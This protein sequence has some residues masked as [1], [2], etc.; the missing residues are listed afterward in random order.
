MKEERAEGIVLKTFDYKENER[1]VTVFTSHEGV[2]ALIAKHIKNQNK[3]ALTTPFCQAEFLFTKGKSDLCKLQDGTILND[4]HFL[5][6][7]LPHL[8][9]AAEMVKIVLKS[10]LPGKP[11]PQL[12][13]LLLACLSQLAH[14]TDTFTLIGSF[15]LKLLMHEGLLSW[16]SSH[17]FPFTVTDIEW[18]SL[19]QLALTRSFKEMHSMSLTPALIDKLKSKISLAFIDN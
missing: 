7:S 12:Y 9:A 15:Y 4:H 10:Q 13:A 18:N 3:I 19:K 1:I 5:R 14:F 6:R 11:A 8:Q 17:L 16:E 2:I